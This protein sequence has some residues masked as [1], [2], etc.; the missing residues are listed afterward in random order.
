MCSFVVGFFFFLLL[1]DIRFAN[2]VH[3]LCVVVAYVIGVEY[4]IV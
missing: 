1:L 2:S 4:S 3:A